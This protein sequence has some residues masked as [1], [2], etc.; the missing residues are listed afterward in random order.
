MEDSLNMRRWVQNTV[1]KATKGD[2]L[3]QTQ[4]GDHFATREDPLGPKQA[5]RAIELDKAAALKW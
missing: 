3:A 4:L 1:A 2:A 5:P